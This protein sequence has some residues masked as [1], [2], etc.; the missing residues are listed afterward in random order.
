[1]KDYS[2]NILLVSKVLLDKSN[3]PINVAQCVHYIYS[4][5]NRP[6]QEDLGSCFGF[7]WEL[8]QEYKSLCPW[9]HSWNHC[10][11]KLF[12]NQ[13][14][15]R[16]PLTNSSGIVHELSGGYIHCHRGECKE[17][18]PWYESEVITSMHVS[19]FS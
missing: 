11:I 19:L 1:M 6:P 8:P 5:S 2:L 18:E 17:S 9:K 14:Y 12:I 7:P 4:T 3:Q 10:D 15:D 13:A 16:G